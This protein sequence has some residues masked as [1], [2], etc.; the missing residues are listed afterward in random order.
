MQPFGPEGGEADLFA[1]FRMN[2]EP[3][4]LIKTPRLAA[5]K[6]TA[7]EWISPPDRTRRMTAMK[8]MDRA[9]PIRMTPSRA[10]E[11]FSIFP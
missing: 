2:A 10:S 4:K 7:G 6:P 9:S 3:Q 11:T 8:V 5:V 1:N